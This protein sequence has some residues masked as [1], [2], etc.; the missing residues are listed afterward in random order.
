MPDCDFCE[1]AA[2]RSPAEIVFED[3]DS[4]AFIPLRP[5]AV[6]HAL[7]IPKRHIVDIYELDASAGAPLIEATTRVANA[8]KRALS[9][10]GMN[11]ISSAGAAAT[12]T[13]FHLHLHLVPRWTGDHIGDI[14]PPSEPW[15]DSATEGVAGVIRDSVRK[16]ESRHP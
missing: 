14:W 5:A 1:I 2:G 9:P 13:V 8:I 3:D 4:V 11:L 6:G 16:Y 12:Q 10:D 15:S 7:I